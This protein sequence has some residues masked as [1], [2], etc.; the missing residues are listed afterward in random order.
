MKLFRKCGEGLPKERLP[1]V[2]TAIMYKIDNHI[3]KVDLNNL[4]QSVLKEINTIAVV[5]F[6]L[7]LQVEPDHID[8]ST[9]GTYSTYDTYGTYITQMVKEFSV[10]A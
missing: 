1:I 4:S 9:Y 2:A 8:K 7:C 3:Q 10:M 6:K 5:Y